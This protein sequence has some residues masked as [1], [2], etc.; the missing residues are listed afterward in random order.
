MSDPKTSAELWKKLLAQFVG[1]P[2]TEETL[3]QIQDTIKRQLVWPEPASTTDADILQRGLSQYY[4][5]YRGYP[6]VM[7]VSKDFS[8]K[9]ISFDPPSGTLYDPEGCIGW[10]RG[11]PIRESEDL[12]SGMVIFNQLASDHPFIPS[13]PGMRVQLSRSQ[14]SE[15][16]VAEEKAAESTEDTRNLLQIRDSLERKYLQALEVCLDGLLEW[17]PNSDTTA[18]TCAEAY[19]ILKDT[20]SPTSF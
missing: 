11:I 17:G 7:W 19:A 2:Y 18:K 5:H 14:M 16:D 8:S 6:E 12:P 9:D 1:A 3:E 15:Q 20:G 10:Y 13:T 4:L